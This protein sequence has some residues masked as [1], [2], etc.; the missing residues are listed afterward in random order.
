MPAGG[1]TGSGRRTF[2][3]KRDE[4]LTLLR[5][6]RNSNMTSRLLTSTIVLMTLLAVATCK[7]EEKQPDLQMQKLEDNVKILADENRK[8]VTEIQQLR[9]D[10]EQQR[11]EA[12]SSEAAGAED[13]MTV[14]R[15]KAELEPLLKDVVQR[16]KRARETPSKGTHFGLRMQYKLDRAVYGLIRNEDP[17]VPYSAKVI[18]PYEKYLESEEVSR[19]YGDGNTIFY[20]AYAAD[21][22]IFQRFE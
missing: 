18:V 17:A 19:S 15:M 12:A 7:K 6:S 9:Q 10:L 1:P 2:S 13:E 16:I 20:F 21:R 22:W 14:E 3:T 4:R 11:Q 8:L 5:K